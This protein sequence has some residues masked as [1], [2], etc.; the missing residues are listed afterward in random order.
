M[1]SLIIHLRDGA[2]PCWMVCN[3][4]G[5]VV[6]NAV[7]GELAH[8]APMAT[9]R[10]VAIILPAGEALVTDSEA[11]AKSAAKLAQVIPYALEE[12]V[13]DEIENLHFAL[14]D[15]DSTTG[16]VPVVV[17]DRELIDARLAEVRAA[18]LNPTAVYSEAS[19]LPAM[20][21]QLIALLDGDSL[22]LRSA[23]SPPL[24]MP[25]L[26]I[27]D[28]FEIA[29]ASQTAPVPGLEAAAP[30]LLIYAGHDEWQ[31]HES[32]VDAWRDRF[33]GVKVQ[34]LPNGPLNLLAPAA[35]AG[36]AVNILQGALAVDSPL[37]TGW[38]AWRVAAVLAGVLLCL[39]LGS[40]FFELHR[41][42]KTE[43]ALNT[44]I[45]EAFRTAMPGTQNT[46]DARRRVAKRLD[47]VRSGGGGNL[48]PALA[49][50]AAARNAAPST[51]IEGMNYREGV[52]DLRVISPD[53]ASLDAIGQQLKAGAWQA[54]I[55]DLTAS[56][57]SYRGR[58]QIRKAGA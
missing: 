24:V 50:L 46:T 13:A 53:A 34:L 57:D 29:L 9:G 36:D 3:P 12:R 56:G 43:A 51:T 40:R 55:K 52:L 6:V 14:G 45:E 38:R 8:A 1:E 5:H 31:A 28:A 41:L 49:A 20:P 11:P 39:H 47:E 10:K 22:T 27:N 19:L 4:D 26:S 25:A 23:D 15:R 33:T 42:K 16:R 17:I 48:L 37:E 18:G 58:L 21:G 7:S 2:S 32:T 35:A 44:S 54:E 30:G